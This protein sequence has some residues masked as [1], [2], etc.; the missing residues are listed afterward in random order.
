MNML[1]AIDIGN[2][3][4]TAGVFE[5]DRLRAT[6]RIATDV[7]RTGDE[8]GVLFLNW[9]P[10]EG[11]A[12]ADVTD[13]VLCSGVPPLVGTFNEMCRRYFGIAPLVV[14]ACIKTGV[15]ILYDNPREV[16]A[17][18]VADAVA[19]HRLYGGP[20]I[21]VDFGTGTVFDAISK[22]G[23]YLGGAIAPGIAI[24]AEA[25]FER[26]AKLP[27]IELVRP[28]HA[29]GRNTVQSMQSGLVFGYVGLIEGLVA[30]FKQE[31][32]GTARVVATGGLA[33]VIARETSVVDVVDLNLTLEGL[34]LV[35]ELN[36]P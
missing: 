20:V 17:D 23:D 35:Y 12:P 22:D 34:R 3:N 21:V 29:I 30:R 24:A 31:M 19:A 18:R 4:I 7:H 5:G 11:L 2:T 13:A 8:Y 14:E 1:L 32:G 36:R 10:R 27:R 16:G 25:L 28:K 33:E 26:A 6:W 9:L 15:R